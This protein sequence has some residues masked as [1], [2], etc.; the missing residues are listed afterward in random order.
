MLLEFDGT[1]LFALISFIIFVILMNLILYRPIMKIM[2]EMQKYLDKNKDTAAQSKQK[3]AEVLQ[4]MEDEI[5][6][7]K[8]QASNILS[9][10]QNEIKAEKNTALKDKK[11]E[12]KEK[13]SSYN[14]GLQSQKDEAENALKNEI[15]DFVKMTV[16]KVLRADINTLQYDIN[17]EPERINKVMEGQKNA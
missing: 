12:I 5:L 9:E 2:D 3:A 4:N 13:I 11:E 14:A 1:F 7:A 15:N 10:T 17:I 8:L 16:S 6:S